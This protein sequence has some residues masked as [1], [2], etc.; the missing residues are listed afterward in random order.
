VLS[1]II[2]AA[3]TG[4]FQQK[5]TEEFDTGKESSATKAKQKVGYHSLLIPKDGVTVQ[6]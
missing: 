1:S 6:L 5:E 3:G 4:A 2:T